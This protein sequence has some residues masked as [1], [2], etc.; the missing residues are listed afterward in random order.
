MKRKAPRSGSY[1]FSMW[2]MLDERTEDE[3]KALIGY[4]YEPEDPMVMHYPDGSGYPGSPTMI[5]VTSVM[6]HS[7]RKVEWG[8]IPEATRE[9]IEE[10]CWEDVKMRSER[11]ND[12][13]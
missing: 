8:S 3:V 1:K 2:I 6:L 4:D 7:G 5:E 9:H 10:Q 11:A 13:Y 12:P